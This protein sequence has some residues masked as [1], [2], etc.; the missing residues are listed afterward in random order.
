MMFTRLRGG[1]ER[2]SACKQLLEIRR[3]FTF[4]RTRRS[5]I[6]PLRGHLCAAV[7]KFKSV[8]EDVEDEWKRHRPH[9]E[10]G[11]DHKEAWRHEP[12]WAHEQ[13]AYEQ[14]RWK[15]REELRWEAPQAEFRRGGQGGAAIS[16]IAREEAR[17]VMSP[18]VDRAVSW[19]ERP[20]SWPEYARETAIGD[21]VKEAWA[22][23]P[24][25]RRDWRSTERWW[26]AS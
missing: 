7:G 11:W 12:A 23:S 15:P 8:S 14:P 1:A 18:G 13:P 19:A 22:P 24:H 17:A 9:W 20:T 2:R 3:T 26:S 16:E 5:A 25:W 6:A 4:N 10:H 21:Y